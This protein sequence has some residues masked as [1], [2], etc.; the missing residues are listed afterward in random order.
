MNVNGLNLYTPATR[1]DTSNQF[2]KLSDTNQAD[3]HRGQNDS[4]TIS[5]AASAAAQG[6]AHQQDPVDRYQA[7]ASN[8]AVERNRQA[9]APAKISREDFMKTALQST[10]DQRIGV[11]RE[12]LQELEEQMQKVAENT[13][14]TAEQKAE[15][16]AA[17][18]QQRD[19]IIEKAAKNTIRQEQNA[20]IAKE[21]EQI[22]SKI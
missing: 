18:E 11:D 19:E 3:N 7:L 21:Q 4:V 5:P 2:Q 12:K 14:L 13:N 1:V 16:L 9:M 15:Q 17:L 22:A 6:Q 20:Q 8:Q 10:L